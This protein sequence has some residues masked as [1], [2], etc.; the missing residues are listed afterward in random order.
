[1]FVWAADLVP[2]PRSPRRRS[3]LPHEILRVLV[4]LV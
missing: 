1:V 4:V 2:Q 3:L